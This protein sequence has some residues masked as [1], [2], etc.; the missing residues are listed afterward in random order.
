MR[1]YKK[2]RKLSRGNNGR[3]KLQGA[4]A[5]L[6]TNAA[7]GAVASRIAKTYTGKKYFK[8]NPTKL[9][10]AVK[11]TGN[12]RGTSSSYNVVRRANSEGYITPI[13]KVIG[14]SKSGLSFSEKV[15]KIMNPPQTM[16][17]QSTQ[18]IEAVSGRQGVAGFTIGNVYFSD[19]F[20]YMAAGKSDNSATSS[21][22]IDPTAVSNQVNHLWTSTLHTFMNSGNLTTELDI[23]VFRALQDIGAADQ[24]ISAS[25]AWSYAE[26]INSIASITNDGTDR[27]GK[28]PTDTS[29]KYYINRW[30]KLLSKSTVSMK[31]GESFKHYFRHHYNTPFMRYMLSGD[32]SGATKYHSLSFVYVVR[33]Q[34]VGSN[35]SADLSTG[36]AQISCVRQTKIQFNYSQNIRPRDYVVGTDLTQIAT[37]NQIFVNTDTSGQTIGYVE[38]A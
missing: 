17:Y 23:Y 5:G 28:K 27:I 29:A 37:A 8:L 7:I 36:D 6:Y 13:Q 15:Q 12:L 4:V 25:S 3:R 1:T 31:P 35:L 19:F 21:S 30:W 38:D 9:V 18:K 10:N 16:L 14:N 22:I 32:T 33:G 34:V 24:P 11:K 2:S 26:S 20:G